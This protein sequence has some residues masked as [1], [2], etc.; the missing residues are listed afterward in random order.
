V[1]NKNAY[2]YVLTNKKGIEKVLFL[3]NNK[4]ISEFK[5]NQIKENI[6]INFPNFHFL[7]YLD[8]DLNNH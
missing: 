1:K 4:I 5:Y 8:Q 7:K 6:L 2:I 3:I